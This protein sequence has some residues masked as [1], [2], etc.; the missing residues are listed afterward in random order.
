MLGRG[1]SP[2]RK[3]GDPPAGA[4]RKAGE[5]PTKAGPPLLRKPA[6]G[7]GAPTPSP[8]RR[9]S[10]SETGARRP[11]TEAAAPPLRKVSPP[12]PL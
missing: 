6:D 3:P 2:T 4:P 1:S 11:G 7:A 9:P 5:S 8:V 12:V 10:P